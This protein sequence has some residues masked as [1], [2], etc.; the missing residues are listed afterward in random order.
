MITCWYSSYFE[1]IVVKYFIMKTARNLRY[2]SMIS[3]VQSNN[4]QSLNP[5]LELYLIVLLILNTLYIY[6]EIPC[7]PNIRLFLRYF[8]IIYCLRYSIRY[9]GPISHVFLKAARSLYFTYKKTV[10]R[11]VSFFI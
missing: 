6:V 11:C 7:R 4:V 3:L 1:N 2:S 10:K 5:I 8:C 9:I